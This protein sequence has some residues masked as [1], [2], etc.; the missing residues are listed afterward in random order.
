MKLVNMKLEIDFHE[1]AFIIDE[2]L[3]KKN[4][5]LLSGVTIQ[6]DVYGECFA[7]MIGIPGEVGEEV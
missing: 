6:K 7:V 5:K 2:Y 4:I 1:A 3:T